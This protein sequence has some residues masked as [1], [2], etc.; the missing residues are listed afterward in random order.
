[1]AEEILNNESQQEKVEDNNYIEAIKEMKKNTVDIKTYQ[2]VKDENKKLL[3][4]L[5]EGKQIETPAKQQR[6]SVEE[7]SKAFLNPNQSMYSGVKA[8][9]ELR[10]AVLEE[11][12]RD[13]FC[14]SGF[15]I[16]ATQEDQKAA[17]KL[18]EGLQYCLD[19]ADGDPKK[20]QR[21]LD[22]IT[23]DV[24]PNFDTSGT[25]APLLQNARRR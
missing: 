17:Q 2:K 7:L 10:E 22:D 6:K 20:F 14:P 16:K 4:A 1:M 15:K 11:E 8:V 25:A 3:E 21:A 5:V 18:A 13:I 12:G 24:S 19:V 23:I 9:M